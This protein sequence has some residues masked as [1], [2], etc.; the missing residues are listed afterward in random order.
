MMRGSIIALAAA[1]S[2]LLVALTACQETPADDTAIIEEYQEEIS[3]LKAENHRLETEV[4]EL[5]RYV[6][7][8]QALLEARAPGAP[9]PWSQEG[10]EFSREMEAL[11]ADPSVPEG[12]SPDY[13]EWTEK[14]EILSAL[15]DGPGLRGPEPGVLVSSLAAHLGGEPL[16]QDLW[17]I[18]TRA[19]RTDS[20]RALGIIMLWGFKDD[21]TA[22]IDYRLHLKMNDGI[23]EITRVD[24]RHH[25][26]RGVTGGL[27]R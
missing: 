14:P 10:L 18:T 5:G 2:V 6:E 19:F 26:W 20:D 25:C 15:S 24:V 8:L 16:G 11:K 17:Q 21:G 27:C 12:Y 1:A 9:L 7:E 23:W 4:T 22:G 13:T 3:R